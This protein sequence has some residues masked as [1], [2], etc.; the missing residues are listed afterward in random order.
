MKT[1]W[2]NVSKDITV[3]E[4]SSNLQKT[5]IRKNAGG[6]KSNERPETARFTCTITMF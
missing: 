2:E 4:T 6:K 3:K 1:A 5:H